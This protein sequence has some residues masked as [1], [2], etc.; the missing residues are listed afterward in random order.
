MAGWRSELAVPGSNQRMISKALASEADVVFL[1]LEDAVAEGEKTAAR[2]TV[3]QAIREG[4]WGD[5]RPAFRVNPL[6]SPRFYRDLIDVVETAGE[7]VALVVLPKVNRPED[8]YVADTLLTQVEA[9]LGRSQKIGIE[10]Q[11]ETAEGLIN[12]ERVAAASPR[13]EALTFGPGD[14]AASAGMPAAK[15]G[16]PDAWDDRFPGHRWSYAMSRIVIAARAAGIRPI[17]GPFADF[18]DLEGLR[19][20]AEIARALGFD[21]KWCIHPAQIPIVNDVFSPSEDE[22]AWA[23]RVLAALAAAERAGAGAVDVDGQMLDGAS[24]RM[25]QRTLAGLEE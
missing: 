20:S 18:R 2:A 6:D 24:I 11:I 14:F 19:R 23:R 9:H 17:D 15:I 25:A 10:A 4:D 3:A 12:C 1:D 8:V 21:G 13:V 16:M 7:R 5:K 22:V